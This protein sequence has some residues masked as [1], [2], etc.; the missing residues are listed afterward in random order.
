MT[1]PLTGQAGVLQMVAILCTAE[2][3]ALMTVLSVSAI[4]T[5]GDMQGGGSYYM[6]SRSLGYA[7]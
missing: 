2:M 7:Q 6:I 5:N 4:A 3:M 1:S